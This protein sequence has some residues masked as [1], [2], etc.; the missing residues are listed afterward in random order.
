MQ[1][2]MQRQFQV[3]LHQKLALISLLCDVMHSQDGGPTRVR[4]AVQAEAECPCRVRRAW[5]VVQNISSCFAHCVLGQ[6]GGVRRCALGFRLWFAWLVCR[7]KPFLSIRFSQENIILRSLNS[8]PGN[9][10]SLPATA[11]AKQA[12]HAPQERKEARGQ[13]VANSVSGIWELEAYRI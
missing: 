3:F 7:S 11:L 5:V 13:K 4:R 12:A 8:N 6:A 1:S 2:Q 10:D 9:S